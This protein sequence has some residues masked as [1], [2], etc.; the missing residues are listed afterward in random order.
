MPSAFGDKLG[1]H[2]GLIILSHYNIPKVHRD[3]CKDINFIY[4]IICRMY[5]SIGHEINQMKA[6]AI[7]A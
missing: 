1:E 5:Y 4:N 2:C 3:W 7:L 6:I